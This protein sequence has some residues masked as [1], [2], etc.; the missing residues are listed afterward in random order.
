MLK[1]IGKSLLIEGGNERVLVIGDVHIGYGNRGEA[2]DIFVNSGLFDALIKDFEEIS[3]AVGKID[4]IILLGDLKHSLSAIADE[5]KYGLINLLDY[6][7]KKTKEIVIIKGNH[8][9]Y[10]LNLTSRR[11]I[12]VL[13]YYIWKGYCFLHGDKDFLEIYDKKIKYWVMGHIHPAIKLY[14]G[15]KV[16]KYKCF[17]SGKFRGKKIIILPSFLEV[18]DGIDVRELDREMPWNFKLEDFDVFVVGSELEV[19]KFGKLKKIQ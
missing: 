3:N 11:K 19:L 7:E 1:Y 5:E 2:M 16:E 8:D 6:L 17:L 13:D 4:K 12:K 14:E 9:N 18:G 15:S 10:L